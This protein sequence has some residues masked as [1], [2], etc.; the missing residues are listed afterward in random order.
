VP[1]DR[2]VA[3]F[4]LCGA[5][6]PLA[7]ERSADRTYPVS[8]PPLSPMPPAPIRRLQNCAVMATSSAAPK[9]L[10]PMTL[11]SSSP[12]SVA[13]GVAPT[14]ATPCSHGSRH[15]AGP[16]SC[17]RGST[18][19]VTASSRGTCFSSSSL[20]GRRA[21]A[22]QELSSAAR[23]FA[24]KDEAPPLCPPLDSGA[25]RAFHRGSCKE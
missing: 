16:T 2:S 20:P 7:A 19:V 8:P 24:R 3:N 5:S 1:F 12:R 18:S 13:A 14:A 25:T 10:P 21:P 22:R 23:S 9:R 6:P 17:A 4:S 15:N 11:S